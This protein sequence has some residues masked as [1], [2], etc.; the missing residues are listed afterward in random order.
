MKDLFYWF[1][2]EKWSVSWTDNNFCDALIRICCCRRCFSCI[3]SIQLL[4]ESTTNSS[5]IIHSWYVPLLVLVYDK[6]IW[7]VS[8]FRWKNISNTQISFAL[9]NI[10]LTNFISIYKLVT[11]YYIIFLFLYS[12]CLVYVIS[13]YRFPYKSK[14]SI[15]CWLLP[16]WKRMTYAFAIP[17]IQTSSCWNKLQRSVYVFVV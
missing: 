10:F 6:R 9:T 11:L 17:L 4:F 3:L 13:A 15:C 2:Y 7:N 14:V 16:L 5:F 8:S 12:T 1:P